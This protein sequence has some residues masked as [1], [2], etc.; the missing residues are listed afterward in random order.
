MKY[1]ILILTLVTITTTSCAQTKQPRKKSV[2]TTKVSVNTDSLIHRAA[3]VAIDSLRAKGY[4]K[5]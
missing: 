5:D 1:I 4:I 2:K 3:L